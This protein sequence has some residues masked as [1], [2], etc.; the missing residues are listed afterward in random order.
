MRNAPFL[1]IACIISCLSLLTGCSQDRGGDSA[2]SSSTSYEAVRHLVKIMEKQPGG[3]GRPISD[4]TAWEHYTSK[5]PVAGAISKAERY[6]DE[7]VPA[8]PDSLYLQFSRTG[9]RYT[10]QSPQGQRR[11]ALTWLVLGECIED[12]GRFILAA[13]RYIEAICAEPTWVLPAHDRDLGNFHGDRVDIDLGSARTGHILATAAWMMENRFS[14]DIRKMIGTSLRERIFDPFLDEVHSDSTRFWWTTTTNN[15]NSVCLAGVVGAAMA[16]IESPEERAWFIYGVEKYAPNYL[17]GF[18]AGGYCSEGLSYWN[19]GFGHYIVLTEAVRKATGGKLDLFAEDKVRNIASFPLN[20]RI[21]GDIYPAFADCPVDMTPSPRYMRYISR[22]LGIGIDEYGNVQYSASGSL[23]DLA[24]FVLDDPGDPVTSSVRQASS[25]ELRH[26]FPEAGVLIARPRP[27]MPDAMGVALKGGHNA[28]HHNHN[29]VGSYVIALGGRTPLLD[30]G[31]TVYTADTF[32]EH[33]YEN[34]I[35]NSYGH[36][37][38][39]VAGQLQRTGEDA[40]AV[41][42]KQTFTDEEDTLALDIASAYDV[43][44]LSGLERTFIFNR[45]GRGSLTVTDRVTFSEPSS[46]E[47]A[48]VSFDRIAQTG[49]DT[50]TAGEGGGAVRI[51]IDTGGLPYHVACGDVS[52]RFDMRKPGRLTR[53]AVELDGKVTEATVTLYIEPAE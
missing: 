13:E 1:L 51:R 3:F 49:T 52:A 53:A 15:W 36:P 37:V 44:A 11:T 10:Y 43:P 22:R 14:P 29:D 30:P 9:E 2:Q 7:P 23:N 35:L 42:T 50:W 27:D 12:S 17:D 21:T 34:P 4:R 25:D 46:F 16:V 32:N 28:E 26:W 24:L 38:P 19:Y 5:P 31:K 39:V 20:L 41:V 48:F 47:T 33:R 6:M 8:L 40:H 18:T 45:D